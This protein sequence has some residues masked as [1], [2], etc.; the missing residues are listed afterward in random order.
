MLNYDDHILVG[1]K[2]SLSL[3]TGDHILAV[4][5]RWWVRR[6]LSPPALSE[7]V[8]YTHVCPHC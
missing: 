5:V 3:H 1:T 7:L 8:T 2:L 6:E 4:P